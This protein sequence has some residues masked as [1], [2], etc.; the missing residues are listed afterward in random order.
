MMQPAVPFGGLASSPQLQGN[1]F[2]GVQSMPGLQ[3]LVGNLDQNA[4]MPARPKRAAYDPTTADATI[5]LQST[6]HALSQQLQMMDTLA[7]SLQPLVEVSPALLKVTQ[8]WPALVT[9]LNTNT[10]AIKNVAVTHGTQIKQLSENM[11]SHNDEMKKISHELQDMKQKLDGIK[12]SRPAASTSAGAALYEENSEDIIESSRRLVLSLPVPKLSK[13]DAEKAVKKTIADVGTTIEHLQAEIDAA[14]FYPGADETK[15]VLKFSDLSSRKEAQAL[16]CESIVGGKGKGSKLKH[17]GAA[18][19]IRVQ[20]AP[21]HRR[22]DKKLT[23]MQKAHMK[24]K[25]TE[26]YL[27]F[28]IDWDSRSITNA[29]TGKANFVQQQFGIWAVVPV[30]NNI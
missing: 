27:D 17:N 28:P 30:Q 18:V 29:A 19:R 13:E 15:V 14:G 2:A 24:I 9:Q 1:L 10:E 3:S 6:S 16:I 7:R 26:N 5:E 4:L 8:E 23:E 11:S 25:G 20:K 22:R 12:N 21:F